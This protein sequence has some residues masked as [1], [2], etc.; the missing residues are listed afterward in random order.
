MIR[1]SLSILNNELGVSRRNF[2]SY[3]YN[4]MAYMG[5]NEIREPFILKHHLG[6]R[7]LAE[8]N[9]MA[10]GRMI[11]TDL[12]TSGISISATINDNFESI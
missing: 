7:V 5:S 1:V 9:L 6:F 12:Y 2:E 3:N 10:R 8:E 11:S 4:C